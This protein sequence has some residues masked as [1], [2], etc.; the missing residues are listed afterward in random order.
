MWQG[1]DRSFTRALERE[2]IEVQDTA[3]I[4]KVLFRRKRDNADGGDWLDAYTRQEDGFKAGDLLAVGG[5]N[6]LLVQRDHRE[7]GVY[8]RFNAVRCNQTITLGKWVRSTEPNDFGEY[9]NI[10]TPYATT[11]AYMVTQ[12][13]GLNKTVIGSVLGGTVAVIMPAYPIDVNVPVKCHYPNLYKSKQYDSAGQLRRKPGFETTKKSRPIL[14]NDFREA[15]ENGEV[16]INS[17]T[18]LS[19]MQ[20]F[21]DKGG[22][23]EHA[24]TTGDDAVFAFGMAL[25]GIKSGLWYL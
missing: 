7:N 25:Q 15:F 10:F 6:Y 16:C 12:L 9:L 20:L 13:T 18:L 3:G 1:I 24:G 11:P 2:G 21:V 14:I 23:M 19:E 8:S 17:K 22:R 4:S 5:D